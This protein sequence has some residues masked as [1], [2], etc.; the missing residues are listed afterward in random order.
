MLTRQQGFC[1]TL[2]GRAKEQAVLAQQ[3]GIR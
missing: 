3:P 1:H 2:T